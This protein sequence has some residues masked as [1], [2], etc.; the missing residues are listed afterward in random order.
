MD[1]LFLGTGAGMPA[2][3]RNVSSIALNLNQER[4]AV[5]LFDCGEATQHQIL[6]TAIRPRRIEHIFI[7]HMHG[8][9][10][11]GLPGLL[12]S[13]SFQD[14]TTPLT[15]FGPP[16]LQQFVETTLSLS[17]TRLRYPIRVVE[18]E[19]GV[20]FEDKQFTVEMRKL[21]HGIPSF[22]YRVTEHDKPG[23]LLVDKLKEQQVPPGPLYQRLKEGE[24]VELANGKVLN[25]NDY[26]G[27]KKKGRKLAVLGDTRPC[28]AAVELARN[29]DVLIHE[30]TFA[31][32][33]AD[34]A[35]EYYHSTTV[36]AA[37]IAKEAGA[38]KLILTHISSRYQEEGSVQLLQEA[39]NVFSN[40]E[41]A[42]DFAQFQV[43]WS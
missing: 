41:V 28:E 14:G 33:E 8:D 16:G 13:R 24:T 17:Q 20:V 11:F 27:P 34:I 30:A 22:G 15:L 1:F 3:K 29:V 36:Q 37:Q 2:K 7:T 5:W 10:I 9:H 25:G 18:G 23:E 35:H 19:E 21:E 40:T 26:I 42:Y 38:K 31:E 4:R 12:G 6:H 43:E 39:R 32:D